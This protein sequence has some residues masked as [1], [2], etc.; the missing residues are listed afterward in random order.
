MEEELDPR[1]GIIPVDIFN[2]EH[3]T[4]IAKK[5]IHHLFTWT[6]RNVST[7]VQVIANSEPDNTTTWPGMEENTFYGISPMSA[8]LPSVPTSQ[9]TFL[10]FLAKMTS[11][12]V[13]SLIVLTKFSI[14]PETET[15]V[16]F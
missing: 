5:P 16:I 4:Y 13:M 3:R 12:S 2:F 9:A 8:T 7:D 1:P 10:T 15:P 14:S 6:T 11:W